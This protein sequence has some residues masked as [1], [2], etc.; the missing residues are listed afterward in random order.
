MDAPDLCMPRSKQHTNTADAL[1]LSFHLF[2][3]LDLSVSG[4]L[5]QGHSAP[6][7]CAGKQC[8][9]ENTFFF[10][11]GYV[12]EKNWPHVQNSLSWVN[13]S[14]EPDQQ[15]SYS[16]SQHSQYLFCFDFQ[17]CR[18][19]GHCMQLCSCNNHGELPGES[20]SSMNLLS[21]KKQGERGRVRARHTHD[22]LTFAC[23][24]SVS[25]KCAEFLVPGNYVRRTM[26]AGCVSIVSTLPGYE[27]QL[28]KVSS[29]PILQLQQC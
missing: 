27:A 17:S 15:T 6:V 24:V 25:S 28:M 3:A 29:V 26:T 9:L 4:C 18:G 16:Y 5:P 20:G 19:H 12:G 22:I 2:R 23:I 10:F 14:G 11:G 8:L 7:P 13:R 21:E 1:D